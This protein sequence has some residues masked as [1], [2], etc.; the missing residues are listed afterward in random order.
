MKIIHLSDLHIGKRVLGYS[1]LENQKYILDRIVEIIE[2]EKPD[3]VAIA[4]DVY[5]KTNPSEEAVNLLDD[6]LVRLSKLDAEVFVLSGN[7]DS[8]EKIAF[9]SRLI[10]ASG[11]HMSPVY[12]G[13]LSSYKL[14]DEYGD[15]NIYMLPFIK[16]LHVRRYYPEAIISNYTD[17]VKV[18]LDK[19]N[20]DSSKRNILIAHQFV[21]GSK[22][23]DSEISVGG[24][25]NVDA[26]CFLPFDYVALGHIH[27]PQDVVKNKIRYCGTPLKYSFSEEKQN[28][29]V[30]V[31][32][33]KEKG[34][35]KVTLRELKPLYDFVVV[36]GTFEDIMEKYKNRII[37]DYVQ[38]VLKDE[39]D[40]PDA[41][42]RLQ[43][44]FVNLMHM[45]YDNKRT[46]E[47]KRLENLP[48][49]KELSEL[50][51][52]SEL[53]KLQ[54]NRALTKEQEKYIEKIIDKVKEDC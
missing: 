36:T 27:T 30:T 32:E 51:M 49:E 18:A 17:A 8:P 14:T 6:F 43:N 2:D 35:V 34:D 23:C 37:N 40:V 22:T 26:D 24:V 41:F 13:M 45:S 38:I 15:V 4:G 47:R 29:S 50:E 9:A 12:N 7:H 54:H 28:K 21:T 25:E 52:V 3:V 10:D 42:R 46:N 39:N 53:Y 11:I 19:M 33:I 1:M 16:P 44:I 31:I 5:D 20:I 48:I